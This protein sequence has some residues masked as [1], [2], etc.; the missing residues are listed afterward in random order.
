MAT[1]YRAYFDMSGRPEDHAG[2]VVC[3][4]IS[5]SDQWDR[6][7]PDWNRIL[8]EEGVGETDGYRALHMKDLAASVR[9]FKGWTP[10]QKARLLSRLGLLLRIRVQFLVGRGVPISVYEASQ[11]SLMNGRTGWSVSPLTWCATACVEEV[12]GWCQ[13]AD[14]TESDTIFYV[15]E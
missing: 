4:C 7:E 5:P 6:L 13:R 14:L 1:E 8:Q 12:G 2:V 15:F 11:A 9:S 3:G 10:K